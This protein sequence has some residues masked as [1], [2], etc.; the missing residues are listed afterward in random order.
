MQL[1]WDEIG[2]RFYETGISKGVLYPQNVLTG[3]YPLGVAWNGLTGIT[4]S[5]SGAEPNPLYADNIKYLNLISVEE[6]GASVEAFTYPDEFAACDGSLAISAGIMAGQQKRR[7]F[8][9]AYK[10]NLGNDLADN[11]YGY[12]L[13]LIYGAV[14]APSEKAYATINDTPE[15]ITFSWEISTT[16]VS[17]SGFKATASLTIDSTKVDAG[18]L[19]ALEAILYGTGASDPRLPLPDEIASMF[20]APAPSALALS[21]IVPDDEDADTAINSTIVFTFN[22]AIQRESIIVTDADGVYVGGVKT[23]NSTGKILTFTPTAPLV[24]DTIYLVTIGG[25]VDIYGQALASVVKN[26]STVA[27]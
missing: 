23:W 7:P 9:L 13:H 1:I 25:V 4:E 22:N 24:N 11:E 16:P 2:K 18:I 27:L 15:A 5:P 26:F 3:L 19:A 12:K 17:V 10:T 14:A 8:G 6:F 20:A 21:T